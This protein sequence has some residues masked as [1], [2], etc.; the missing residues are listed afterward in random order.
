M[1]SNTICIVSLAFG[2]DIITKGKRCV[3]VVF[4]KGKDHRDLVK[5]DVS[6]KRKKGGIWVE[7]STILCEITCDDGSVYK[8]AAC[9]RA[10]LLEVNLRLLEEPELLNTKPRTDG[11]IAL[12]APKVADVM[13]IQKS[14]LTSEEYIRFFKDRQATESSA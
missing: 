5:N 11:F 12:F 3:K 4:G 9:I 8:I 6:G 14:L 7:E 2:H 13:N 10:R 1:H